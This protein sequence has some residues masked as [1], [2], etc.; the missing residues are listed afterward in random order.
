MSTFLS[1]AAA[2][3]AG[4]FGR[5]CQVHVVLRLHLRPTCHHRCEA[6]KRQL[7]MVATLHRHVPHPQTLV[8][9]IP[10][11]APLRIQNPGGIDKC[12]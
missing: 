11:A 6:R 3:E 4:D 9:Q 10:L 2:F 1:A 8:L 12:T 5:E 7:P